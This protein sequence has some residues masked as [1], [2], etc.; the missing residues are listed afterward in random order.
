MGQGKSC[1][2]CFDVPDFIVGIK[3]GDTKGAGLHNAVY[4]TFI[5]D[6]GQQ[7]REIHLNGCCVTVFKKGRTDEFNVSKLPGFGHVK[8][9]VIQ[10]HEEQGD[11]DWY[12]DKVT[13][14][15]TFDDANGKVSVFPINR[16]MKPNKPLRIT[17]FDSVLPQFDEMPDQRKA[18]LTAKQVKYGYHKL[19]GLPAQVFTRFFYCSFYSSLI[20]AFNLVQ[21]SIAQRL[22][23]KPQR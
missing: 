23:E 5:N 22:L 15:H 6:E 4:I 10:Q 2:E 19:R 7:S 14:R 17:V 21:R 16:W 12:L 3:T 8:S 13:V 18:E 9:I 1:F 11:V 20:L